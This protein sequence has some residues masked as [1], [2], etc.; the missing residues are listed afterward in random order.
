ML[1]QEIELHA[2]RALVSLRPGVAPSELTRVVKGNL[3]SEARRCL[4]LRGLWSRGWFVRSVGAV[5]NEVVRK[6]VANQFEHHRATPPEHPE[7]AAL[8]RYHS[9]GDPSRLRTAAHA[10]FEYNVH[11]VFVTRRRFDFLDTQ[12]ANQ[13]V[14]Y[15]QRVCDKHRWLPW[16]IE[17]VW[18]HAHLFLGLRP[19]DSPQSVA[20][21]L[22]NSDCKS[23]NTHG[24][25]TSLI[26]RATAL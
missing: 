22:M 17:V 11:V 12:A 6:Y 7:T 4:S 10:V 24:G 14:A 20:L 25:R 13:L 19:T 23:M 18:N 8:A 2:I 9:G 1:E 26:F 15:W 16:D 5:T 21:N 3:A